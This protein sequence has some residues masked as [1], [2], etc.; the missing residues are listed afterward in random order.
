MEE[1]RDTADDFSN[2]KILNYIFQEFNKFIKGEDVCDSRKS[3]NQH[4]HHRVLKEILKSEEN[5]LIYA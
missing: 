2:E 1:Y 5:L 4:G 3:V